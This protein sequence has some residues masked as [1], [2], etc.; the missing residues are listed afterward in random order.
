MSRRLALML[1]TPKNM[2]I[3]RGRFKIDMALKLG[4]KCRLGELRCGKLD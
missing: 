2:T 1:I 3:E 4:S